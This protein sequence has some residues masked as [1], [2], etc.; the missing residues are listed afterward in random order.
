M[1]LIGVLGWNTGYL[2]NNEVENMVQ[3]RE[4]FDKL[5]PDMGFSDKILDYD[6]GDYEF[7]TMEQTSIFVH[8]YTNSKNPNIRLRI[9]DD[10]PLRIVMMEKKGNVTY[11][12]TWNG[13]K[14]VKWKEEGGHIEHINQ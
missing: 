11:G 14:Q 2:Y 10:F 8:E 7:D 4:I 12:T 9:K 13:D 1:L 3:L 6:V 5:G